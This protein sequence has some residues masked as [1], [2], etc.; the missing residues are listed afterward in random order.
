MRRQRFVSLLTRLVEVRLQVRPAPADTTS[1]TKDPVTACLPHWATTVVLRATS[2]FT[3]L[4][5]VNWG[6][7]Q[8]WEL[9][10]GTSTKSVEADTAEHRLLTTLVTDSAVLSTTKATNERIIMAN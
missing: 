2:A 5:A 7:A 10:A 3:E 4:T 6:W 1:A 8:L 9:T